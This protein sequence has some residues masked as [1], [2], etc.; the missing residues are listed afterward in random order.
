[1]REIERQDLLGMVRQ[2]K[3]EGFSY[4]SKITA[5][6]YPDRIEVMYLLTDLENKRDEIIRVRLQAN[7]L[8]VPTL[9]SVFKG[10]DWHE[11]ELS[12]M[13]GIEIKGRRAPRLL[14][15]KWDGV[16][17]PLRKTFKWGEKYRSAD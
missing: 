11:R 2:I 16:D 5:V 6:D 8:W 17:P 9:L 7:D 4:L 15:D 10:A 14:L 1:M 12:E 3:D 13:F